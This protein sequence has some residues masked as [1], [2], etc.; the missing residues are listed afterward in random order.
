MLAL[1]CVA[2][3]LAGVL[4]PTPQPDSPESEV[5][6]P[7]EM[8]LIERDA[9]RA[10][11]ETLPTAG[12][13]LDG[14]REEAGPLSVRVQDRWGRPMSGRPVWVVTPLR[15]VNAI[16]GKA[17]T[18]ADG[19]VT[20]SQVPY[21]GSYAVV[22]GPN[23]SVPDAKVPVTSRRMMI[24][25]DALP[26]RLQIVSSE[27]G[28]ALS[29]V[30]YTLK[31]MVDGARGL[32]GDGQSLLFDCRFP[33][34]SRIEL[35]PVPPDGLLAFDD[36]KER[37]VI[38][39]AARALTYLMPLRPEVDVHVTLPKGR[40]RWR[41]EVSVAERGIPHV[42]AVSDAFGRIRLRNIPFV[43]GAA[44]QI[45]AYAHKRKAH[46]AFFFGLDADDAVSVALK[47]PK[48]LLKPTLAAAV[49]PAPDGDGGFE[50]VLNL[51]NGGDLPPVPVFEEDNGSPSEPPRARRVILR[52]Y[53]P[54]GRPAKGA[55]VALGTQGGVANHLGRAA[56]DI[57]ASGRMQVRVH[58]VGPSWSISVNV[59]ERPR[60]FFDIHIQPPG[61]IDVV[62]VGA[63]EQPIPYAR[64]A[65]TQ[66][67]KLPWFDIQDGVQ[68]LDPFTDHRGRR[69]LTNLE[70][71]T[72]IEVTAAIGSRS[73]AAT[74]MVGAG[75][76]KRMV[77]DLSEPTPPEEL[78]EFRSPHSPIW[79]PR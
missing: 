72:P 74:L 77:I 26:L 62:V 69:R 3:L 30:P 42:H 25:L 79:T 65:V 7:A 27:T 78:V 44:V 19:R 5:T 36:S 73:R 24:E 35:K 53:T 21:D 51:L 39:P 71:H 55:R 45:T 8:A 28:R 38:A 12:P 63:D 34:G 6:A 66:G 50:Y 17:T 61:T 41:Y 40:A 64:L 68:R 20:F 54:D 67:S 52:V 56:F 43:P 48:L 58:G 70:P 10:T 1:G 32:S 47:E 15:W 60:Q 14:Q 49:A 11:A 4:V 46:G 59:D 31:P 37:I 22:L 75:E 9:D 33:R 57:R 16:E 23:P 13:G 29:G 2:W 76:T 18:D